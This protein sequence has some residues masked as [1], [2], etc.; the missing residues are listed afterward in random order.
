MKTLEHLD[1]KQLE[2]AV[3]TATDAWESIVE[4]IS[5]TMADDVLPAARRGIKTTQR[6]INRKRSH[7]K[8]NITVTLLVAA[9]AAVLV[10]WWLRRS[11]PEKLYVEGV[12]QDRNIEAA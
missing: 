7:T 5:E 4:R 8:R 11:D 1:T 12:Q 3:D 2:S 9:G 6:K 10:M